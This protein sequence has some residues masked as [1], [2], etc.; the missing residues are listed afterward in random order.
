MPFT[1]ILSSFGTKGAVIIGIERDENHQKTEVKKG[2][3]VILKELRSFTLKSK[4]DLNV[5]N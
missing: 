2:D 3:V 1:K 5:Q 4:K